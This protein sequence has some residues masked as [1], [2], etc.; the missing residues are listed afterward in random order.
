MHVK[1]SEEEYPKESVYHPSTIIEE[2]VVCAF[3]LPISEVSSDQPSQSE[4][5][6][7][8]ATEERSSDQ[9]ESESEQ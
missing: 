4:A 3:A 6:T 1:F 9:V 7:E 5:S 8:V 2:L